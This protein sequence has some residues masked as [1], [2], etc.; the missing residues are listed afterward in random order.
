MYIRTDPTGKI[1]K[2]EPVLQE[3]LNVLGKLHGVANDDFELEPV[4]S[5][6]GL[7]NISPAR[8]D[9]AGPLVFVHKG[10]VEWV[11][12]D[13]TATRDLFYVKNSEGNWVFTDDFF[14]IAREFTSVT[15]PR[16]VFVYFVRHGFLPPGKT[17]FHEIARVRVGTRLIFEEQRTREESIWETGEQK[18]RTYEMFKRGFSSVFEAYPFGEEAAISLRAGAD[19]GLVAAVA[20]VKQRKHPLGI[21][22]VT[23]NQPLKVNDID[24]A[25]VGRI[26]K[27]LGLEHTV[28][29][30]DFN[31]HHAAELSEITRTMPIA[32]HLSLQHFEIGEEAK[33]KGKTQVWQGQ[34]ADSAYNL[35]PT[36]KSWGGPLRRFYL[37]KEYWQGLPDV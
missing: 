28:L 25:N 11:A 15:F 21:T 31:A 9:A 22:T 30:F 32:A 24:E 10:S 6:N 4:S 20:A 35:G 23:P 12:P 27:H 1:F 34:S 18:P 37:T 2:A 26:T 8:I 3:G 7:E 16:E 19:S 13:I 29:E 33:R 36:Q 14:L 5:P 17:F